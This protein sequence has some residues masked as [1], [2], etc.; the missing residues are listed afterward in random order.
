[1]KKISLA[2]AAALISSAAVKADDNFSGFRGSLAGSWNVATTTD[3]ALYTISG[4][5]LIVATA[6]ATGAV[7]LV[8]T[9]TFSQ[10]FAAGRL[11][12]GYTKVMANNMLVGANIFGNYSAESIAGQT[13]V[14]APATASAVAL[15]TGETLAGGMGVGADLNLGMVVMPKLAIRLLGGVDYSKFNLTVVTGGANVTA[16]GT[17]S[18]WNLGASAGLALDFAATDRLLISVGGR[19]NFMPSTITITT[20]NN[21]AILKADRTFARASSYNLFAEIGFRITQN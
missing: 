17:A 19:Y 12:L 5:S 18:D 3:N 8:Y 14:V 13:A 6:A 10:G 4:S 9:P 2:L 15:A 11:N 21:T 20:A 1:M 7:N 16:A